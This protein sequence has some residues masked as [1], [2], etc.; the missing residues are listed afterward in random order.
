M[1]NR[2]L[3]LISLVAAFCAIPAAFADGAL[4]VPGNELSSSVQSLYESA[5]KLS[6]GNSLLAVHVNEVNMKLAALQLRFK[7]LAME[8]DRLSEQA[9]MLQENDPV[10]ARKI[11]SMEKESFDIDA[12]VEA[13]KGKIK[14]D[15]DAMALAPIQEARFDRRLNELGLAQDSLPV[16][17]DPSAKEKLRLLKMIEESKK[18]QEDLYAKIISGQVSVPVVRVESSAQKNALLAAIRRAQEEVDQLNAMSAARPQDD[19]DALQFKQLQ[20]QV[21]ALQKSHDELEGLVTRMQQKLQDVRKNDEQ[22]TEYGRLKENLAQINKET[23]SLK[24][25]LTD[26]RIKMVELDKRKT[27]LEAMT[28]N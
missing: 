23:Q 9:L 6:V 7:Q 11:A 8:N 3:F 5:Q 20:V 1:K 24:M 12:Q 19:G 22:R 2:S 15:A 10:K 14:A 28:R 13:L 26:L 25:Q 16:V 18:R 4:P 17:I 27:Y 21:N